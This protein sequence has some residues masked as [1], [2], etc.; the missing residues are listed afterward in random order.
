MQ[1]T[2]VI[3]LDE[4][5]AL[6]AGDLTLTHSLDLPQAIAYATALKH[7]VQYVT[8]NPRLKGLEH[9]TLLQNEPRDMPLLA[10][11]KGKPIA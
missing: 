1:K 10:Y 2:K 7:D 4:D 6:M 9:I 8:A 5:I 11:G 3:P